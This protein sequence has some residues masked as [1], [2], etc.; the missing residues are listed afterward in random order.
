MDI[1]QNNLEIWMRE[2]DQ[3]NLPDRETLMTFIPTK[4]KKEPEH[5]KTATKKALNAGRLDDLVDQF[6]LALELWNSP[7]MRTAPIRDVARATSH[8]YNLGIRTNPKIKPTRT[9]RRKGKQT[10]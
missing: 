4:I 6:T 8:N 5:N 1:P 2:F 7:E 3:G 9:T 10:L